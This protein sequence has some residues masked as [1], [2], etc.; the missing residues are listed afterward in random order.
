MDNLINN[1]FIQF[2]DNFEFFREEDIIKTTN[3]YDLDY[4]NAAF[5]FNV[6]EN[7]EYFDF[8]YKPKISF[9]NNCYLSSHKESFNSQKNEETK[10]KQLNNNT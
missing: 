4:F 8:N 1:R 2:K 10:I 7:E 6:S 3:Y 9:V 5:E